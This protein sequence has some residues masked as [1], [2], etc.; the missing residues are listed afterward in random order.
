MLF[1]ENLREKTNLFM[2]VQV[3]DIIRLPSG[4]TKETA[5]HSDQE[6]K[7]EREI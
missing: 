4:N 5:R 3:W 7:R 2:D 6:V 1:T